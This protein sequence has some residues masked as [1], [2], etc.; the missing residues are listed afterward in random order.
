LFGDVDFISYPIQLNVMMFNIFVRS[1]QLFCS[2]CLI[3]LFVENNNLFVLL[4]YLFLVA[5][6][7]YLVLKNVF[8]KYRANIG[9]CGVV[10]KILS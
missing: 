10:L 2:S 8:K 9:K 1:T 5:E 4:K 7:N 6:I 3:F